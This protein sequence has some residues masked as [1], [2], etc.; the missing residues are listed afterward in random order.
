MNIL[1]TYGSGANKLRF[2]DKNVYPCD[3]VAI[4]P[5]YMFIHQLQAKQIHE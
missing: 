1:L 4:Y 5:H 3:A 2:G